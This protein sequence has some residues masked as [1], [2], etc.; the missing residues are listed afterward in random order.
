MKTIIKT[1]DLDLI[2]VDNHA[3]S[4][5]GAFRKQARRE[6]WTNEE[7]KEVIDEAMSGD[8]DHLLSTIQEHCEP[9]YE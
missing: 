6:D 5:I 2:G 9:T 8:Y 1:V 7:I 3:L 4:I